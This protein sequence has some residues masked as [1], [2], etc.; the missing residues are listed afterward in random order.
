[1]LNRNIVSP[2]DN[3]PYVVSGPN[4]LKKWLFPA[5]ASQ[6]RI[7]IK[8]GQLR[9]ILQISNKTVNI[10]SGPSADLWMIR[11]LDSFHSKSVQPGQ[12]ILFVF[13]IDQRLKFWIIVK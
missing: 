8:N 12:C 2:K 10:I 1:M 6:I 5:G 3:L 7:H 13:P 11:P 4:L 9:G